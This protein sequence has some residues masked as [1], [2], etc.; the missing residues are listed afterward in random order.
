MAGSLEKSTPTTPRCSLLFYFSISRV[1]KKNTA[2]HS[3][4]EW[5][6]PGPSMSIYNGNPSGLRNGGLGG[7]VSWAWSLTDCA[8]Q[9]WVTKS[10]KALSSNRLWS[11]C[12]EMAHPGF[13]Y[14][15]FSKGTAEPND[16]LFHV[17]SEKAPN[18]C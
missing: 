8:I 15:L 6:G 9:I 2:A 4:F 13:E 17:P 7:S 11:H 1:A 5:Q 18:Y 16:V 10:V 3:A 12:S 14:P